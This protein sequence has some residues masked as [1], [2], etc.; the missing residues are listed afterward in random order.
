MNEKEIE[1]FHKK[2]SDLIYSVRKAFDEK[3]DRGV[4]I[5]A[6]DLLDN[7]L[8]ELLNLKLIGS[9]N[10]KEDLF[11]YTGPLGTFSSRQKLAYSTGLLHKETYDDL[12]IIR[13][14]RNKF[15][16]SH[17]HLD[18]NT[19]KIS[20]E[21]KNMVSHIYN[22]KES[23]PRNVFTNT[24]IG[25]AVAIYGS[26]LLAENFKSIQKPDFLNEEFKQKIKPDS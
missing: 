24:I 10:L 1:E 25:V 20:N 22:V 17:L 12:Q 16:H 19:N 18:F 7:L 13:R 3:T 6:S 9:N 23:E 5:M 21:I 15:S 26:Q 4:C 8:K 11:S 14:I 2:Q